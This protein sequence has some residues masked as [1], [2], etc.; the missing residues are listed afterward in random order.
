M[1]YIENGF[2]VQPSLRILLCI[3]HT[4]LLLSHDSIIHFISSEYVYNKKKFKNEM[5]KFS[6]SRNE[7]KEVGQFKVGLL[8]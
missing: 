4:N 1:S 5:E 3:L 8:K 6:T 2:C 7:N